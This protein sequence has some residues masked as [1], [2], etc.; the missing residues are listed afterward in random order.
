MNEMN[1]ENNKILYKDENYAIRGALFEV[2][3]NLGPGFAED[4]YQLALETELKIR[5]IPF[6]AQKEYEISYKGIVLN[7][8]FRTDIICYGKIILE[9]KSVK[10]ILPEHMAQILNYL[11]ISDLK[12][13]MLVNFNSYPE[14]EIIPYANFRTRS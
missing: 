6:E 12:M 1:V 4:V 7:K 8:T 5:D 2:H 13:G 11:R 10:N 3:N 9:L 14:L